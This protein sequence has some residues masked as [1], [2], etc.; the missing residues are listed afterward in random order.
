MGTNATKKLVSCLQCNTAI[1]ERI[2]LA[3]A[4]ERQKLFDAKAKKAPMLRIETNKLYHQRKISSKI[5]SPDEVTTE[6]SLISNK[7][8]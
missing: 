6:D 7:Y 5:A 3:K 4:I 2:K 8:F 1:E